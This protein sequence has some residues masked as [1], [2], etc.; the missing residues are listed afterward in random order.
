MANVLTEGSSLVCAHQGKVTLTASQSALTVDGKKVIVQSDLMGAPI[1]GCANVTNPV[2]GTKQCMT[3]T[4][5]MAGM[6][7]KLTAGG[8]PVM[9]DS[10]QGMTD[11]SGPG[12]VMWQVQT[13]GQTKLTA[14]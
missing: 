3:V 5:V 8:K 7:T 13:A 1:S 6:A 2:T 12:P 10:A 14:S 4:S 9:L 11:G